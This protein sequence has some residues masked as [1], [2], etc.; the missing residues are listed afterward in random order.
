MRTTSDARRVPPQMM[1]A[2]FR[3]ILKKRVREGGED[4]GGGKG[5]GGG[6][7]HF[8][9]AGVY[10][11]ASPIRISFRRRNHGRYEDAKDVRQG[12]RWG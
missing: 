6:R 9:G 4:G 2:H 10:G 3:D 11:A 1:N 5:A 12:G 7:G 8:R